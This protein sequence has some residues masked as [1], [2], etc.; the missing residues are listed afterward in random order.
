MK[1]IIKEVIPDIRKVYS[2]WNFAAMIT[3]MII[4]LQNPEKLRTPGQPTELRLLILIFY[5]VMILG[6][7]VDV[8]RF[9]YR[10]IAF[11][12]GYRDLMNTPMHEDYK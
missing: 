8:T 11:E 10:R 9:I 3:L 4:I 6:W 12:K 1:D 5:G 2:Y 7:L